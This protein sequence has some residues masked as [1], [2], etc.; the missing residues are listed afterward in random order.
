[1]GQLRPTGLRTEYLESPRGITTSQP[2]LSWHL[3]GDGHDRRQTAY[4]IRVATNPKSLKQDKFSTDPTG[5]R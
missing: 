2:R 1:M 3:A 4:Q 5:P